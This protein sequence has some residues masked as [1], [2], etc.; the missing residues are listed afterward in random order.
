MPRRSIALGPQDLSANTAAHEFGH[1]LGFVDRYFRGYR[2]LESDGYEILEVV[3]N[4]ADIM[5]APGYGKV[6]RSHFDTILAGLPKETPVGPP[7]LP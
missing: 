3:P 1:I 7:L 5:A 6:L 4:Y 2:D